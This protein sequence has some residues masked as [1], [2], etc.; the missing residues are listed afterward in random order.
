M[1]AQAITSA[2]IGLTEGVL[3]WQPTVDGQLLPEHP[4][5]I[6][7]QGRAIRVPTLIGTNRDE[8]KLFMIG[9]RGGQ[10]LSEGQLAQRLQAGCGAELVILSLPGMVN[11]ANELA[12]QLEGRAKNFAGQFDVPGLM[13]AI[14]Y[15]S[16][17]IAL[18]SLSINSAVASLYSMAPSMPV[19]RNCE[20]LSLAK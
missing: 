4:L 13:D 12:T 11:E 2:R 10:R 18:T 16:L 8:W 20:A 14:P 19:F 17:M 6:L 3:A 15:C 5:S 9:D 1:R 7:D